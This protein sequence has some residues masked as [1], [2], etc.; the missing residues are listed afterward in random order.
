MNIL[1]RRNNIFNYGTPQPLNIILIIFLV[2][3]IGLSYTLIQSDK[4][5]KEALEALI[6]PEIK[7]VLKD[8][9]ISAL[10]VEEDQI[11]VGGSNGVVILDS[12]SGEVKEVLTT[13]LRLIYAAAMIRSE[14]GLLWI[15]HEKG[16]SIYDGK[17]WRHISTPEIPKG[18]CNSLVIHK[19]QILA[20]LQGGSVVFE[21][22]Q[23]GEYQVKQIFTKK[24]GLVE[25]VVNTIWVDKEE[26]IWFGSYLSNQ[27]GGISILSDKGWNYYSVKE[28]LPHK[29][30]T[31]IKGFRF[32]ESEYIVVGTGHLNRG[33][34]ALFLNSKEHIQLEKVFTLS[35]GLPGEKVRYIYIAD[36][37]DIWITTEANGLIIC[38]LS[39]LCNSDKV[40]GVYL[41][42]SNGLSD[43][44]IKIMGENENSYILGGRYGL[45]LIPKEI[46]EGLI[47]N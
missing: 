13:E 44:E 2:V 22:D 23:L 37:Q 4:V 3:F 40:T 1:A 43:N 29:Y 26:R 8:M 11:I 10:L 46:V 34:L 39:S 27:T 24:E 16:I 20:G 6:I 12:Q 28:G 47:T 7:V 31:D 38:Q 5:R 21:K 14:E 30:I 19:D 45:S 33:G 17:Q 41:D 15:G 18:R 32:K 25:D 36:N 9:E 35:D 42:K